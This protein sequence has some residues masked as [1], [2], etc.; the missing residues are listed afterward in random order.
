MYASSQTAQ[1]LDKYHEYRVIMVMLSINLIIGVSFS[2]N[3]A[4]EATDIPYFVLGVS[5]T[6]L[7]GII[8]GLTHS[9][10]AARVCLL[11]Y[12]LMAMIHIATAVSCVMRIEIE[13]GTIIS[14]L[15]LVLLM[16]EAIFIMGICEF[17]K[18]CRVYHA[19]LNQNDD[20]YS[21]LLPNQEFETHNKMNDTADPTRG[22]PFLI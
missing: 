19:T 9:I 16:C 12:L 13:E 11:G 6:G 14:L 18:L 21:L 3:L 7:I 10:T 1:L 8:A 4:S 15:L 17:I 20:M 5:M 22:T 2:H